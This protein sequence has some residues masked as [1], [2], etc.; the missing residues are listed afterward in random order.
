MRAVCIYTHRKNH[1]HT[2]NRNKTREERGRE[3]ICDLPKVT[4]LPSGYRNLD[5]GPPKLSTARETHED[6]LETKPSV[7]VM[8][9][10]GLEPLSA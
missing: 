3:R 10:V 5:S 4:W 8:K 6:M 1:S 7:S 2:N 9:T